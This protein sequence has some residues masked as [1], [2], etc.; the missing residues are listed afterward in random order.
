MQLEQAVREVVRVRLDRRCWLLRAR[1]LC[2]ARPI[3][4]AR[5]SVGAS[6]VQVVEA[7]AHGKSL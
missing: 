6:I 5:S 2:T 7:P 4:F 1:A 3:S